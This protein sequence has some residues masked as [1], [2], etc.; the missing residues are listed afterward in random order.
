MNLVAKFTSMH[1]DVMKWRHFPRNW[2]FVRGIHRSPVNS[3]HK[4]QW[5]GALVFSLICVWINGWVNNHEAGD[6]RH[7]RTHYVVVVMATSEVVIFLFRWI[8]EHGIPRLWLCAWT[9]ALA[10]VRLR[11]GD[12]RQFRAS[13]GKFLNIFPVM[14][15]LRLNL[16]MF[17]NV[18]CALST[19]SR[20][21]RA[22]CNSVLAFTFIF[23]R[24]FTSACFVSNVF[25]F[26]K[27]MP[28]FPRRCSNW[29]WRTKIVSFRRVI[30]PA[31]SA[32][33]L[34]SSPLATF[35]LRRSSLFSSSLSVISVWKYTPSLLAKIDQ[36]KIAA[37]LE[38]A[39]ADGI[40]K[41]ISFCLKSVTVF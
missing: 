32:H 18:S 23:S 22:R 25:R 41:S 26:S 3:P 40:F 12:I 15:G 31:L 30:S 8:N 38:T 24:R 9:S 10:M 2:P 7:H 6:L 17:F 35:R 16:R 28:I 21:W 36:D 5:R 4:G 13:S 39:P 29:R 19:R 14:S 33:A 34:T 11:T 27:M 37:I 1:D 20:S